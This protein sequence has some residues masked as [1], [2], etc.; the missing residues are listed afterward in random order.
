MNS[1]SRLRQASLFS[2]LL[3]F[4]GAL[5]ITQMGCDGGASNPP[6]AETHDYSITNSG[7]TEAFDVASN[8]G[9]S[10]S[11]SNIETA[12]PNE[13]GTLVPSATVDYGFDY[14]P[15]P[16]YVG[17]FTFTYTLSNNAGTSSPATVTVTVTNTAPV[18]N[19]DSV[20]TEMDSA[21]SI[22]VRDNDQD[23]D[24]NIDTSLV[25]ITVAPDNGSATYDT[26]TLQIL[27]TPNTDF[28][29]TDTFSYTLGDLG[30]LTSDP[31]TVTVTVVAT[32][33]N[34]P[35]V[36]NEDLASTNEDEAVVIDVLSNDTDADG[37]LVA[38][39]VTIT[40][41]PTDGSVEVNTTNGA[42][43]YT[44]DNGFSGS[45]SFTYTVQD[46][47]GDTSNIA[48]VTISVD[49]K[50]EVSDDFASTT[51]DTAVDI[52]VLSNDS[53]DE[54][55][56]TATLEIVTNPGNGTV[57]IS[58]GVITYTPGSGFTGTDVFTYRVADSAMQYS[59]T[60]TVTV[61]VSAQNNSGSRVIT[62]IDALGDAVDAYAVSLTDAS[63]TFKQ[64]FTSD[65]TGTITITG[66][67]AD[68]KVIMFKPCEDSGSGCADIEVWDFAGYSKN[69]YTL[70]LTLLNKPAST[71]DEELTAVDIRA[72]LTTLPGDAAVSINQDSCT[73]PDVLVRDFDPLIPDLT[74]P[75]D[76]AVVTD[77]NAYS[78]LK[79]ASGE[80]L[81]HYMC[82]TTVSDGIC[83][84]DDYQTEQSEFYI[85]YMEM[86]GTTGCDG[87]ALRSIQTT[88]ETR[89]VNNGSLGPVTCQQELIDDD[90]R[91][92]P[93]YNPNSCRVYEE[94]DATNADMS[95]P[96]FTSLAVESEATLTMEAYYSI[97]DSA[98][99]E[100]YSLYEQEIIIQFV[101]G[102]FSTIYGTNVLVPTV[103]MDFA[104][105]AGLGT[106]TWVAPTNNYATHS[107]VT[108]Q[109]QLGDDVFK[110]TAILD[111]EAT[112][113]VVPLMVADTMI[114]ESSCSFHDV[115]QEYF[116]ADDEEALANDTVGTLGDNLNPR[117]LTYDGTIMLQVPA[118]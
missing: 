66:F 4:I 109:C 85:N 73:Y 90:A 70:V 77:L 97:S 117:T 88:V 29:G 86:L 49:G 18:A 107:R 45:D 8:D 40:S 79:D 63:G 22:D 62:V 112:S 58:N 41:S 48:T 68:D 44:P 5:F 11:S 81:G 10:V 3:I 56:A 89:N 13:V 24:D 20:T 74:Q 9:S 103:D 98:V 2:T 7:Q 93:P 105:G 60:A 32:G 67:D 42:V 96:V 116:V 104:A 91:T 35:P 21:V 64:E 38:S 26:A 115:Y 51:E 84:L 54:A 94:T 65:A 95:V 61:T 33:S 1:P 30:G 28:V 50:P 72:P 47:A 76:E 110:T 17:T 46:D 14:T 83:Q 108:L 16:G 6:S 69:A 102:L 82:N 59:D 52:N 113:F 87:C 100:A 34:Q 114:Y 111:A 92:Y 23:D 31:A 75:C 99:Y 118:S 71:P 55:I 39:S 43:T 36:A 19:N 57:S 37:S 25:T 15:A 78:V 80:Y 53:D 106:I 12:P 27:Y 101:D